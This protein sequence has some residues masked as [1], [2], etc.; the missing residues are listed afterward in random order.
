MI[1][2]TPPPE[3]PDFD[4]KVRQ[5]G[6]AWLVKHLNARGKL[7]KGKRPP[8]K[9][10]KFRDEL[11]DGFYN[12][13]GYSAMLDY[14]GTIDHYWCCENRPALAYEWSNYRYVSNWINSSK[15][16]LDDQVLDPF[17]VQDGWFEILLPSMQLVL[18]DAVPPEKRVRAE[19]T[20]KRLGLQDDE[21]VVRLRYMWYQMYLR[22]ELSLVGLEKVAP[23]IARAVRKQT[24]KKD[25]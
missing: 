11:A 9:W 13:C 10:S 8:D 22:N 4:Q 25:H 6:R 23:L 20:L 16:I 15:G 21:R 5:P 12:R 7:P 24:E 2:V 17:E 19:F 3:P 1:Q 18:T 14:A